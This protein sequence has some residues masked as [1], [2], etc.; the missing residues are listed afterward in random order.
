MTSAALQSFATVAAAA[1]AALW[2]CTVTIGNDTAAPKTSIALSGSPPKRTR[3]PDEHR[4]GY[5]E[6][7]VRTYLLLRS[8]IPGTASVALGTDFTVTAD[9][10]NP[11]NVGTVWRTFELDDSSGGAEVRCVCRRLD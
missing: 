3:L 9:A 10:L 6:A 8:Q 1:R 4:G 5:V 2:P 7:T 11:G